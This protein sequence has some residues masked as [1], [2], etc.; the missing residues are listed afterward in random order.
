VTDYPT[1]RPG[2]WARIDT[3]DEGDTLSWSDIETQDPGTRP[4]T[5]IGL[6]AI[7]Y[8]MGGD[9]SG[10]LV[11]RS[12]FLSIQDTLAVWMAG[13]AINSWCCS[14]DECPHKGLIYAVDHGDYGGFALFVRV[15]GADLPDDILDVVR[16]LDG[17]P[18]H[19]DSHYSELESDTAS[20][21][22]IED[23]RKD[24]RRQIARNLSIE[25][26]GSDMT[27][28]LVEGDRFL[29][30]DIETQ[31]D[32]WESIVDDCLDRVIDDLWCEAIET[33]N[34]NGGTSD[35]KYGYVNESGSSI[36]FYVDDA[37][38]QL[39]AGSDVT[40]EDWI[41]RIVAGSHYLDGAVTPKAD[42]EADFAII[43]FTRTLWDPRSATSP[44]PTETETT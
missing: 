31:L 38:E 1:L 28:P 26:D 16:R 29:G 24:F 42:P 14:E 33:F 2:Y 9:Y 44:S 41:R 3:I 36:Y 10:N 43:E 30:L 21:A 27:R 22:W 17:D 4:G 11:E 19:D 5:W 15:D 39:N 25:Y 7:P 32:R 34:L 37:I 40:R 20:S 8:T 18:L 12:N 35:G 13:P 6:A 23:G